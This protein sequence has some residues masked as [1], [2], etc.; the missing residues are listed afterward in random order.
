MDI[1]ERSTICG[2]DC[3]IVVVMTST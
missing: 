1:S 3:R 2:D